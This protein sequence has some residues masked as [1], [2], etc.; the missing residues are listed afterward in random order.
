M[1]TTRRRPLIQQPVTNV[2]RMESGL[3]ELQSSVRE[4]TVMVHELRAI[5]VET[6]SELVSTRE[7]VLRGINTTERSS[8]RLSQQVTRVGRELREAV[9]DV[10]TRSSI[11]PWEMLWLWW[12][13]VWQCTVLMWQLSFTVT[14]NVISV[15]PPILFCCSLGCIVLESGVLIFITDVGLIAASAGLSR[16]FG[17]QYHLYYALTYT[18]LT[19][20][21]SICRRMIN[22]TIDYFTPYAGIVGEVS[23]LTPQSIRAWGQGVMDTVSNYLGSIVEERVRA[24]VAPIASSLRDLPSNM[25]NGTLGR[26]PNATSIMELVDVSMP[27][28][29]TSAYSTVASGAS[30]AAST[31][32]SG[33]SGAKKWVGLGGGPN[34]FEHINL[35]QGNELE[36]FNKSKLGKYLKV[37]HKKLNKEFI[38]KY[39]NNGTILDKQAEQLLTFMN[40][41]SLLVLDTNPYLA[42]QIRLSSPI[43]VEPGLRVALIKSAY[44]VSAQRLSGHHLSGRHLS[45]RRKHKTQRKRTLKFK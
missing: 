34:P 18:L 14:R 11:N 41:A 28:S 20:I 23:G 3:G 29:I 33:L 26:L 30:T 36:M 37:L 45:G 15:T 12:Q 9:R 22:S 42:E 31:V 4:L 7:N 32:A 16:Y 21:P 35:L 40:K 5:G 38:N 1:D 39:G 27:E 25:Y 17:L 10:Y 8:D 44:G 6:A 43:E 24:Q 13:F 2:N 19:L